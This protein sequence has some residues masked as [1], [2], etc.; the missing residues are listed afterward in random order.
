MP[1]LNGPAQIVEDGYERFGAL[2]HESFT[3]ASALAAQLGNFEFNLE[4]V[5]SDITFD[6]DADIGAPFDKPPVPLAPDT[7]FETVDPPFAEGIGGSINVPDVGSPPTFSGVA[8]VFNPPA[9]PSALAESV[10]SDVP[11]VSNPTLPDSPVITLP[12]SPVMRSVVLPDVPTINLP[13]FTDQ[14]PLIDFQAP[15]PEFNYTE[16]AY[17]SQLLAEVTARVRLMLMGGTGLPAIVEQALFDKARVREDLIARKAVAEVLDEW[18]SRGFSLPGGEVNRRLSEVRQVNQDKV[19]TLSRDIMIRVHEVEIENLRFAVQQGIALESILINLYNAAQQ[20]A[21]DVAKFML[22]SSVAIFNAK[23]GL[24]NARLAAFST[25]AEV[26]KAR[27][28]AELAKIEVFKAQLE[29]AKLT[30]EINELDVRM[31]VQR[32]QAVQTFIELYKAQLEAAKTQIEVDRSKVE[33]YRARVDAFGQIVAAKRAEFEA[34]GEEIRGESSK[35]GAFEAEARAYAAEVQGFSSRAEA[36]MVR[37]K[38]EAEVKKVVID[39]YQADIQRYSAEMDA[40]AKRVQAA[41]SMFDGQARMY[42]AELGAESARVSADTRIFELQLEKGR[43]DASVQIE[44]MKARVMQLVESAKIA[45]EALRGA[46]AVSS[47]LAA[48][49]MS[50]VNLSASISG[51]SSDSENINHQLE[52]VSPLSA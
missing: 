42:S 29:G 51:S 28:Q 23:I 35:F 4:P 1:D 34:W 24:Y 14:L 44:I 52:G 6:V 15:N 40:E 41:A 12:D 49:A 10:P 39:K 32:V 27:I 5:N 47:Q 36:L 2:A 3:A 26:Y 50:A 9:K 31:Y 19:S 48:G 17:S 18:S 30:N 45:L 33:L 43:A 8:P 16:V 13:V 22:E 25:Q 38:V 46:A 37:P 20:R 7:E 21:F 11:V